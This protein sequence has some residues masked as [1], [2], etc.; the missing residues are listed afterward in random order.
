[1]GAEEEEEGPLLWPAGGE[2][3]AAGE[4]EVVAGEGRALAEAAEAGA[5]PPGTTS[6]GAG[7]PGGRAK[8][9]ALGTP[10]DGCCCWDG[11]TSLAA[12]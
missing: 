9:A 10:A 1:M 6:L 4:E 11:E 12:C 5:R 7:M 2:E 8:E 3:A